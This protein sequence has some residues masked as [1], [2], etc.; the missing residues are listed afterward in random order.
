MT[1]LWRRR[2]FSFY[3]LL[4]G[5]PSSLRWGQL[6]IE[7]S[8]SS[9]RLLKAMLSCQDNI[10]PCIYYPSPDDEPGQEKSLIWLS[11][12]RAFLPSPKELAARVSPKMQTAA[13]DMS[14][15][16]CNFHTHS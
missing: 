12:V 13:V 11:A 8:S 5:S 1:S 3:P 15:A 6:D 9:G 10:F 4:Q 2:S 7:S 16:V 14:A